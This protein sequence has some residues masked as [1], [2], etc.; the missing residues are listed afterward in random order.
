MRR[1]IWIDPH[2]CWEIGDGRVRRRDVERLL[3]EGGW[4]VQAFR[5]L[6]YCDCWILAHGQ[7]PAA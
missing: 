7:P 4:R 2:H 5:E 3:A 1:R 6:P